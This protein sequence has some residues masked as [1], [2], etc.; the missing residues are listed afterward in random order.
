MVVILIFKTFITLRYP[1]IQRAKPSSHAKKSQALGKCLTSEGAIRILEERRKKK[2]DEERAK[3]TRKVKAAKENC[4][5]CGKKNRKGNKFWVQ[6]DLCDK[7]YHNDCADYEDEEE[8]E[9][10]EFVCC[11]VN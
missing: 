7:W 8:A 1:E 10:R 5:G 6:C 9:D 2:D 11:A 3:Y 4:A